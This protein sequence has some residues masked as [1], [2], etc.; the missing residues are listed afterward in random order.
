MKPPSRCFGFARATAR[1]WVCYCRSIGAP[2]VAARPGAH[3]H[4][5]RSDR[6]VGSCGSDLSGG[7]AAESSTI[8]SWAYR[9]RLPFP[10]RARRSPAVNS[11][12]LGDAE[13]CSDTA[14]LGG[15]REQVRGGIHRCARIYVVLP[16]AGGAVSRYLVPA[17]YADPRRYRRVSRSARAALVARSPE[18]NPTVTVC[19]APTN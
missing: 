10:D 15:R 2:G 3:G 6:D 18:S 9:R 8:D 19:F 14:A 1:Y 17:R 4:S 5:R 16:R 12:P 11:A 7:L 13:P